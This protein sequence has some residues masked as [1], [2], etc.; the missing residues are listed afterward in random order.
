MVTNQ[1]RAEGGAF[2]FLEEA[3][4]NDRSYT[5]VWENEKKRG[6]RNNPENVMT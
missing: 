2:V 5:Q 3:E 1:I 4:V 6:Q